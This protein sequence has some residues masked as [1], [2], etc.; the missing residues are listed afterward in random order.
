MLIMNV[1]NLHDDETDKDSIALGYSASMLGINQFNQ[2]KTSSL[3]LRT[4]LFD[5]SCSSKL[6]EFSSSSKLSNVVSAKTPIVLEKWYLQPML[7]CQAIK[8][9]GTK[10]CDGKFHKSSAIQTRVSLICLHVLIR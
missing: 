10:S 4:S 6:R 1:L 2:R 8:V 7:G 3:K 9:C 5:E